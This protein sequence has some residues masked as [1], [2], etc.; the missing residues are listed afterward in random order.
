MMNFPI[1]VMQQ[2]TLNTNSHLAGESFGVLP[3]EQ[4]MIL[5]QHM[6]FSGEDFNYLDPETNEKYV[7][8]CIEPSLGA[9]RVT[10]SLFN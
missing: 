6:Q 2:Q 9:D 4:I 10:L 7:P 1:T 3:P 5:K 8:Y